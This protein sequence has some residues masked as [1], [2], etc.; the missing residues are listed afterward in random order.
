M[1]DWRDTIVGQAT[2][3]GVGCRA[4]L[5]VAGPEAHR[6]VAES[7]SSVEPLPWRSALRRNVVVELR[8]WNRRVDGWLLAWPQ[9]RSATGQPMAELHL[10]AGAP[11][12]EAL[13]KQLFRS[14]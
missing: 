7:L 11:L 12:L 4:I 8:D 2:A 13:Q 10:P 14:G 5:R 1:L 6:I 3:A 9:R